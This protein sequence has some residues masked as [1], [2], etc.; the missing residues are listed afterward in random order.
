MLR[1]TLIA[2]FIV[3]TSMTVDAMNQAVHA[4]N[5]GLMTNKSRKLRS[6]TRLTSCSGVQLPSRLRVLNDGRVVLPVV[7]WNRHPRSSSS[8]IAPLLVFTLELSLDVLDISRGRFGGNT[9]PKSTPFRLWKHSFGQRNDETEVLVLTWCLTATVPGRATT[10]ASNSSSL[11]STIFVY[12]NL[13]S[14][15]KS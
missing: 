3:A 11:S 5:N 12:K 9:P 6:N 13:Y 15:V 7:N 8:M 14:S 1:P 2:R 4:S 10:G